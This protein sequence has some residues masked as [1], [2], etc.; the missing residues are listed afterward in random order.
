MEILHK[1][2]Q[3]I[4]VEAESTVKYDSASACCSF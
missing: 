3:D 2:P 1:N 4:L